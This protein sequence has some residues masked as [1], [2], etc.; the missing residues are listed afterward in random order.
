MGWRKWLLA[1]VLAVQTTVCMAAAEATSGGADG[2]DHIWDCW[3]SNGSGQLVSYHIRC[4]NDRYF[5]DPSAGVPGLLEGLLDYVHK[6]IHAGEVEAL[7]RDLANGM[8]EVLYGY[9]HSI[10]IHNFPYEESW[11]SERPHALVRAALCPNTARCPVF[12][13]H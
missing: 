1:V 3:V 11:V 7:D 4:I 5:T 13:F 2:D 9:I 8:F 6:M 10:R 12:I